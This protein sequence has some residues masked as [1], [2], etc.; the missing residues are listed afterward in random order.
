MSDF[1]EEIIRYLVRDELSKILDKGLMYSAETVPTET[2]QAKK[3]D[4]PR[5]Q[6][7]QYTIVSEQELL[8]N[9][10]E[11]LQD[12]IHVSDMGE[13][14]FI[15]K[16]YER[17]DEGKRQFARISQVVKNLGGVWISDGKN[18]RWEVPK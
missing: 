7:Q 18:S 1:T 14:Y 6:Q 3:P 17:G 8:A 4:R 15:T 11:D 2:V 12:L 16:P 5:P 10:T 9:F 13:V